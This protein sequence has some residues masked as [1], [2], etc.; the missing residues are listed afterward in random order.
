MMDHFSSPMRCSPL[1]L[2][3]TI[4]I[5]AA[6]PL[7]LFAQDFGYMDTQQELFQQNRHLAES[8]QNLPQGVVGEGWEEG[9]EQ[10]ILE[11]GDL[12]VG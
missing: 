8:M 5:L 6:F 1:I 12:P 7:R 4:L 2:R 10:E 9:K 3:T 11:A